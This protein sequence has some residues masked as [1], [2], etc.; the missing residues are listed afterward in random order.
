MSFRELVRRLRALVARD[1]IARDLD[2]EMRLHLE[3]R[4]R[5]LEQD[6]VSGD[7]A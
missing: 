5:R 6:G 3:L 4:Q 2:D 1:T 7:E